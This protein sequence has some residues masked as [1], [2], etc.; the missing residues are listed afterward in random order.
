MSVGVFHTDLS[1]ILSR[2]FNI[3]WCCSYRAFKCL[4]VCT[5]SISSKIFEKFSTTY[6]HRLF[7]S[8]TFMNSNNSNIADSSKLYL[9]L[10][11]MNASTTGA[12][13]LPLTIC[14]WN[15]ARE[16]KNESAFMNGSCSERAYE[17]RTHSWRLHSAQALTYYKIHLWVR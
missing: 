12:N 3:S 2:S 4:N 5:Y 14:L 13:K 9:P 16:R 10:F 1:K 8:S 11:L 15:E 7:I 17:Q 6:V